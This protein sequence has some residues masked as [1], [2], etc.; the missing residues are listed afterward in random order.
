MRLVHWAVALTFLG[1]LGSGLALGNAELR[2]IPFLGSKLMRE[3]HLTW[4]VLLFVL[5]ALAAS[6]D[7]F[8][9]VRDLWREAVHLDVEDRLW[10]QA[11]LVRLIGREPATTP[12][13][14]L[15]NAGQKLNLLAVLGLASALA[16]SGALLAPLGSS[17]IPVAV[18]ELVYPLH[19]ILAY[20]TIPLIAAH[21]VFATVV[22]A[23]RE[24]LRGIV[25]GSVKRE[26]ARAHHA[27][28]LAGLHSAP[29]D[30]HPSRH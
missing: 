2:G 18:R 30:T 13:A 26:W 23:T 5:P 3:V 29:C 4:G 7:A 14:G 1:L 28:W 9:E 12:T 27:R 21:L 20:C 6:W 25:F 16:L 8:R 17:P 22:P 10:L 24:S 11:M 15:L 19:V